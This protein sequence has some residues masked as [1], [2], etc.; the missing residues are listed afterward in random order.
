MSAVVTDG[1]PRLARRRPALKGLGAAGGLLP[2]GAYVTIFLLVP[3]VAVVVGAFRSPTGQATL[4]NLHLATQSQYRKGY[5]TS[6]ELSII[7]SVL[8]AILGFLVA[9]SIHRAPA[10]SFLRRLVVSL[11]G[12]FANFGG[13]PLA[14]LFISTV[15]N[16]GLLTK[17]L[18]DIHFDLYGD[19][20]FNLYGKSGVV[21]VYLYFQIPLMVLVILPAL[22]GLTP[23]WREAS[24][25][26]GGSTLDYWRHVG[27]PALAPSVLGATLL[28]FGSAFSAYATAEALTSGTI[29]LTPIQIGAFLNGNVLPGQEN[30][31]KALATGMLLIIG[32]VMVVYVLLQRRAAKWSQT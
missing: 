22:E 25:N 28:L 17:W 15:G 7:A 6:I 16:T 9:R 13:V 1:A 23:S 14:F 29:A 24:D 19:T 18:S 27:G 3:A 20:G 5:E 2:F 30:V 21:L 31:G 10:E 4:H 11:S 12:V 8:P 32:A 26:L